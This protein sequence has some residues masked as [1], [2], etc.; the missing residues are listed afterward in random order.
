MIRLVGYLIP[1]ASM[2]QAKH[3]AWFIIW[4]SPPHLPSS[5]ALK[6][7]SARFLTWERRLATGSYNGVTRVA[8]EVSGDACFN[9]RDTIATIRVLE[10]TAP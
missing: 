4:E 6:Q 5:R 1:D 3:S 8:L 7:A 9:E 10:V 2:P